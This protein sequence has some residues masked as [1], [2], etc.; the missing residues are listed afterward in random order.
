MTAKEIVM[1]DAQAMGEGIRDALHDFLKQWCEQTGVAFPD[2]IKD[3][4][5]TIFLAGY[6]AG[7]NN[8]L[9]A[10]RGQQQ[11]V[12]AINEMFNKKQ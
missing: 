8:C 9:H 10:I 6:C 7:H 3:L 5:E 12:D 11:A 1:P 2:T 4:V